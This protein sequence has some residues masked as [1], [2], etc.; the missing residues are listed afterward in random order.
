MIPDCS[1]GACLLA[2]CQDTLQ[3][4]DVGVVLRNRVSIRPGGR[5]GYCG[6]VSDSNTRIYKVT[7]IPTATN[8]CN[9]KQNLLQEQLHR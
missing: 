5:G 6:V 4:L 1:E 9:S 8:S 7:V 2:S 3:V